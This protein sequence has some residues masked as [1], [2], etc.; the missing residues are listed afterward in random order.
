MQVCAKRRHYGFVDVLCS[1]KRK[2]IGEHY[3]N[4]HGVPHVDFFGERSGT[5]MNFPFLINDLF[6]LN[7]F[8]G[9]LR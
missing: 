5:A 4:I 1:D 7:H 6:Y 2:N 9:R 3:L 8:E